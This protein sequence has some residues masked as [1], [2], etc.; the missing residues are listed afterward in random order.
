ME[1]PVALSSL[2]QAI[3]QAEAFFD[4]GTQFCQVVQRIGQGFIADDGDELP[5]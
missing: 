4:V 2:F 3:D 1:Y 5:L